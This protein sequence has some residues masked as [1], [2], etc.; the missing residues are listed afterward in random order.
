VGWGSTFI[1]PWRRI[2]LPAVVVIQELELE[3]WGLRGLPVA[4]YRR[5]V[6]GK[7]P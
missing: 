3:D 2:D 1:L 7:G 4:E 6:A 5:Q